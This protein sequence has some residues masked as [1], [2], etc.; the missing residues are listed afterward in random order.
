MHA[1]TTGTNLLVELILNA[2]PECI[3]IRDADGNLPGTY[4]YSFTPHFLLTYMNIHNSAFG[5]VP[6]H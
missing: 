2:Y 6:P 4:E 1:P 5:G 3:K